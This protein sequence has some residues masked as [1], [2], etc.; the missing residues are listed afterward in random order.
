MRVVFSK[1]A[2]LELEDAT[3]FYELEFKGLGQRFKKEIKKTAI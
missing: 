1:Y 2:K 3:H